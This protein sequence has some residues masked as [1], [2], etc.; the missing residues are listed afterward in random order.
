MQAR[1]MLLLMLL[2]VPQATVA[3]DLGTLSANP[4]DPDSTSN[5]FG[6]GSPFAANGI[7]NPFSPYGSP[8]SNNSATNPYATEAQETT[9]AMF[10]AVR[11]EIT[12]SRRETGARSHE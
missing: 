11:R 1:L 10:M 7:T 2:T 9:P 4:F 8:F 3:E 5:P 6:K 12:Q